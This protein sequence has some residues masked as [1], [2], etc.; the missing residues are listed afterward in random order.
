MSYNVQGSQEWLNWRKSHLTASNIPAVM[1][2]DPWRTPLDVFLE[3]TGMVIKTPNEAMQ[4]GTELEPFAR[5]AYEEYTGIA[6][7]PDVIEHPKH[8]FLG[9][10]LDGIS[11]NHKYI[12]EFKCPGENS[13]FKMKANGIPRHYWIQ[14][15]SQLFCVPEAKEAHFFA[16][17][18]SDEGHVQDIFMQKIN[19]DVDFISQKQ[20]PICEKFW[21]ENIIPKVA[22]ASKYTPIRDI[23]YLMKEERLQKIIEIKRRIEKEEE[24]L[25]EDLLLLSEGRQ[26]EGNLTRI[27]DIYCKGSIDEALLKASG[28]DPD[29]FRRASKQYRRVSFFL[30]KDAE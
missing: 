18:F 12:A 9:A 21:N 17:L 4:R 24:E 26:V 15:Q 7:E 27:S 23:E 13:F 14:V 1:G 2:E 25:K 19:R 28:I 8:K 3:I 16:V 6:V 22:P 29:K 5:R 11:F 30:K 10:S 20:L